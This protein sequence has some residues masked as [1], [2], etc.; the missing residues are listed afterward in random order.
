MN[1]EISEEIINLWPDTKLGI[2]NYDINVEKSSGDFLNFF[3]DETEKIK[4]KYQISDISL[5]RHIKTTREAYK[6]FGKSPQEYRNASEAMLRRII[7]GKGLYR[8]NNV[9]DIV[10]Y[11]RIFNRFIQY[12][13][14]IR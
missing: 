8:I 4:N 13:K 2:I 10:C 9:V 3:D 12:R 5:F 14:Y 7:N 1:F 6:K 11:V